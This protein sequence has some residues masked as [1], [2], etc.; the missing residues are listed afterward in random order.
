[1]YIYLCAVC[2]L[3]KKCTTTLAFTNTLIRRT[4][5]VTVKSLTNILQERI[6][7]VAA[8]Y[9]RRY[10]SSI[11]EP[12]EA[13]YDKSRHFECWSRTSMSNI[14]SMRI[15]VQIVPDIH[16]A[17]LECNYTKQA[18]LPNAHKT[19]MSQHQT[20]YVERL[21]HQCK[22]SCRPRTPACCHHHE[23]QPISTHGSC[24][25]WSPL[26]TSA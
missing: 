6:V 4:R 7:S 12:C 24:T 23:Q 21:L 1:M 2:K 16:A 11:G 17:H 5:L 20:P 19:V 10:I 18:I 13:P 3:T 9:F 22:I 15:A 25:L 14:H 26:I 8:L